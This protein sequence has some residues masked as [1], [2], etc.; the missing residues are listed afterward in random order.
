MRVEFTFAA[1]LIAAISGLPG[2][3]LPRRSALGQKTAVLL[4]AVSSIIGL[5]AAL[6]ELLDG[7]VSS[8][9]I[10]GALPQWT[11]HFTVDPLAAFFLVPIFLL[12]GAG[13][14]YGL[15]YWR[16]AEHLRNGRKLSVCYG[17]LVAGLG[18]VALAGDGI[19]FLFAWEVMALA[20]FFAVS[21][22]DHKPEVS[23]AGWVYLIATHV[24]TLMLFALFALLRAA[25]GSFELKRLQPAEAGVGLQVAIFLLAFIGFGFKAGIMPL[26]FWLPD[27]HAAAPSHVSAV[28]SGVVL[29]IG[30]YG[31]V[32]ILTLLP[33]LPVACGVMVLGVGTI[34]AVFGVAFA[35]GQHDLK[36]LLAYHSIENIGIIVMGLGLA[37]IGVA[38]GRPAWVMLGMGGCLLHVWNHSLFKGLLFLAAGSVVHATGTREIDRLGGLW[39]RMPQT[40]ALFAIGAVAICG[41]PP[42]NGFVSELMIYL[43]LFGAAAD[44]GAGI[45]VIALAAPALAIVG[46]LALACFVK[47]FAAVFLGSARTAAVKRAH[48]APMTM[49]GPMALLAGLCA[50]IGLAP[51]L[52]LQ[53]LERPIAMWGQLSDAPVAR[54]VPCWPVTALN[55][56]LLI[57]VAVGYAWVRGMPRRRTVQ[58]APTWDCGYLRASPRIQYTASSFADTLVGLFRWLL[59]PTFHRSLPTGVFANE[60]KYESHVPDVVLDGWLHPLWG[61]VKVRLASARAL[62]QGRLQWYL[63]Y[64]LLALFV[65]LLSL[66]PAADLARRVL[67]R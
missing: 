45:S 33:G 38:L 46:A 4:M 43:G 23:R 25:S 27:A 50:L 34:S 64:I 28:M 54:F 55:V 29:K 62:Q 56:S 67:G 5:V 40:G 16:Q 65:L 18:L 30:I 11:F 10:P 12:G 37:M 58:A 47:A 61:R 42:L 44:N 60:T 3:A 35:L 6:G 66:V 26:H 1:C 49:V 15:G 19:T 41:L 13:S 31:I 63:L 7:R 2:V 24:G 53:L 14:V 17:A 59:R 21:T 57:A 20:A 36:R 9:T 52:A 22:E 32:R 48:E 39:G 8:M 51:G